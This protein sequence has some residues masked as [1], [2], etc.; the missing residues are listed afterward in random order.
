MDGLFGLLLIFKLLQLLLCRLGLR[1]R[2]RSL[3]VEG[4]ATQKAF[5][6]IQC[7]EGLREEEH[8]ITRANTLPEE[9]EEEDQ[10]PA[11][12]NIT[13]P[14]VG[15]PEVTRH[16]GVFVIAGGATPGHLIRRI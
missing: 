14:E 15:A 6:E 7:E 10:L 12:L 13:R 8:F 4:K 11:V 1:R 9:G 3:A 5:N 2:G 16:P